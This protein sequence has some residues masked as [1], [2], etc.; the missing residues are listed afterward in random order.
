MANL[1]NE[2]EERILNYVTRGLQPGLLVT[3]MRIQLLTTLGA[4]DDPGVPIANA[5]I[6][7]EVTPPTSPQGETRNAKTLRWE[8]LVEPSIVAGYRVMDSGAVFTVT[9]D[10]IPRTNAVGEPTPVIV[11]SGIYEVPAGGLIF[12]AA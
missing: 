2:M 4:G 5:I 12:T 8:G 11:T 7:L 3:P 10:N 9:V 1:T 6:E